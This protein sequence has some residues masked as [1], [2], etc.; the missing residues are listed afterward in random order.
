M[1]AN[2]ELNLWLNAKGTALATLKALQSQL[3]NFRTT[4]AAG[5][6]LNLG[7][8]AANL[9][10]GLPSQILQIAQRAAQLAGSLKDQ[11]EA[12]GVSTDALQVYRF[13]IE[14]AGGKA[15]LF[16]KAVATSNRS[17][18]EARANSGGVAEAF[19]FLGLSAERLSQLPIEERFTEISRAVS[20][21]SDPLKAFTAAGQILGTKNLPTLL[22]AL[23]DVTAKGLT[24][25][26]K[27]LS[28]MGLLMD[29]ETI[30]RLDAAEKAIGRFQ[31]R[32]TITVGE[33][34]V[35]AANVLDSL[36]KNR[37]DTTKAIFGALFAQVQ[38]FQAQQ[39]A[40]IRL[41]ALVSK[42]QP[43]KPVE[44]PASTKVE[45]ASR[46]L[47]IKS[48]IAA[49]DRQRAAIEGNALTDDVEKRNRVVEVLDAQARLLR[50]LSR[51]RADDVSLS[52]D[53]TK[54][55]EAQLAK[56][57]E[58]RDI[59][60]KILAIR[61][62]SS[63]LG[64]ITPGRAERSRRSAAGVN[65]PT[66]NSGAVRV[67]DAGEVGVNDF[68]SQGGSAGQQV[69][70]SITNNIGTAA[71]GVSDVILGWAT[72]ANNFLDVLQNAG[73]SVFQ[74][75]LDTLVKIGFQQVLNG[76]AAKAIAVGWKALT[77]GLRAAD[78]A[79]T[80]AAEATKTPVLATNAAL[81][82]ASSFGIGAVIGIAALALA[83][84]AF[85][86]GFEQGGYTGA[87]PASKPA[88]IVHA[89]E[90]VLTQA[91][92]ARLGIGRIEAFKGGRGYEGGGFVTGEAT[93]APAGGSSGRPVNF[94][95]VDSRREAQRIA[96][97][98]EAESQIFDM[99]YNRRAELLG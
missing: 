71:Q 12:L 59:E 39:D 41:A 3:T 53:E 33:N 26:A 37:V 69:A 14:N 13:A 70:D 94:I 18:V 95:A 45:L 9:L 40:A 11:S 46:E 87:G 55:T 32:T 92:V 88:G 97:N 7:A 67:G 73:L 58:L 25:F 48:Q 83:L 60:A 20:S 62:E 44:Q 89:G 1:A 91:E 75:M 24:P 5:F 56:L 16:D 19:R 76:N 36:A 21:S 29:Q 43:P 57:N 78:T 64:G 22:N 86:A 10:L 38:G 98:S 90:Y 85:L 52:A 15:E 68:L 30:K 4:F 34:L 72:G 81:A 42:A 8:S 63:A 66:Q 35:G 74:S 93:S 99:I 51:L 79:E 31:L 84:G 54:L 28:R 82:S 6:N 49:L 77:S 17:L 96:K 27:E 50:E 65:D 47:V 2:G 61:Q 23:R 80:V